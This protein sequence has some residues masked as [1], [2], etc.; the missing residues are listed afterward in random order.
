MCFECS[1]VRVEQSIRQQYGRSGPVWDA[2][3]AAR[4]RMGNRV[5]PRD[6]DRLARPG[7]NG[8]PVMGGYLWRGKPDLATINAEILA[9][10]RWL[11]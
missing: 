5:K 8:L 7:R 3:T 10:R 6:S 2:H 11:S 9:E 1:L 4:G